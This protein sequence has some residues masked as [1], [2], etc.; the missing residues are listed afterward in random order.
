MVDV[1]HEIQSFLDAQ[2]AEIEENQRRA[3]DILE[4]EGINHDFIP[5][6]DELFW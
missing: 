6:E 4:E 3:S 2:F 5:V 1:A